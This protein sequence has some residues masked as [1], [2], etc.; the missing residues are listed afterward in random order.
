MYISPSRTENNTK[1]SS[2]EQW[3]C[4]RVL[5]F[6]R[7]TASSYLSRGYCAPRS[8]DHS[9]FHPSGVGLSKCVNGNGVNVS[10]WQRS[11]PPPTT[12]PAVTDYNILFEQCMI[13]IQCDSAIRTSRSTTDIDISVSCR[14]S[15]I[16]CGVVEFQLWNIIHHHCQDLLWRPPGAPASQHK[17]KIVNK[18]KIHKNMESLW[19]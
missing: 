17:L 1:L 18:H 13:A 11:R 7:E 6:E 14:R 3:P 8:K 16:G 15:Q 12:S 10:L 19:R 2:V 5:G 4:G 9:A